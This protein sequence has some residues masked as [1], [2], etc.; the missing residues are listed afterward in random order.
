MSSLK[1]RLGRSKSSAGTS[2][3]RSRIFANSNSSSHDSPITRQDSCLTDEHCELKAKTRQLGFFPAKRQQK[4]CFQDIVEAARLK[5]DGGSLLTRN[6]SQGVETEQL[7]L[8]DEAAK[9]TRSGRT[10]RIQS[11]VQGAVNVPRSS[12]PPLLGQVRA[13][14][15]L[16]TSPPPANGG[17]LSSFYL[18][19]LG[20]PR[21]SWQRA[22]S[23]P[24]RT[25]LSATLSDASVHSA[26]WKK[27]I[28]NNA[29]G[30]SPTCKARVNS[31][32]SDDQE[33]KNPYLPM[34][35][36][37]QQAEARK[38]VLSE[39]KDLQLRRSSSFKR[40]LNRMPHSW[41]HRTTSPLATSHGEFVCLFH[42]F[43]W[44]P[45][46]I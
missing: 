18:Q 38:M 21:G 4:V 8:R 1:T 42:S 5:E 17:E 26:M 29:A 14:R 23:H 33:S 12:R 36:S 15:S 39:I 27:A 45:A 13:S 3:S 16:S 44:Q 37:Q 32:D 2:S 9:E 10:Q 20:T 43:F 34:E 31:F 24:K 28:A 40:M 7:P 22:L 35:L 41:T 30:S 25:P 6:D 11:P 46:I 19:R